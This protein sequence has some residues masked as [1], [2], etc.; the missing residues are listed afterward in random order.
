MRLLAWIHRWTGGL[1]GLLLALLGA[2]GTLLLWKEEYLGF[3][4]DG[5]DATPLRD[6][7]SIARATEQMFAAATGT[8]RSIIFAHDGF[9]L[10]TLSTIEGG[11]LYANQAGKFVTGWSSVW[12]RPETLLFDLHHHLLMGEAG[13]IISGVAGLIGIGFIITGLILWWSTRK[14]FKLRLWPARMTRSAIIRQHRDIGVIIA[15][16]LF[17]TMLAG[18]MMVL[19]PVA[20][21]VLLPLSSTEE[22]QAALAPPKA[23]G[24]SA[25][26]IDWQKIYSKAAAH[27]PEAELRVA[28]LPCERGGLVTLRMKQPSE[29]LPNGRTLLWFDPATARLLDSRDANEHP[30][31]LKAFN[32]AYPIHAAKVG[33]W[34]FKMLQTI[35]GLALT[36]L[37]TL[38]VWSFW[39]RKA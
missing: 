5:A 2:T 15:P 16:L 23:K 33:G 22:M 8:P 3:T 18:V 24:G 21:V 35:T 17:I 37:G 19:R 4:L 29:W 9:G 30:V 11:G 39:F 34:A 36:M 27:F 31:G 7:A 32:L 26:N 10:N 1:I 12:D 14:T 13:E 38:A 28:S 20:K 6:P 25:E